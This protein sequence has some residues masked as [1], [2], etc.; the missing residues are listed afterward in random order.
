MIKNILIIIFGLALLLISNYLGHIYPPFSISW[1]PILL[2]LFTILILFITNF[3]LAI[4]FGLITGMIIANDILIKFF[5]GGTHDWEG[6]GWITGFLF[7]GLIISSIL[8]IVYGF[9]KEKNRKKEYFLY[10]FGSSILLFAY[11]SYFE[12][13]GMVWVDYPSENINVSK[14]KGLFISEVSLSDSIVP[15][16]KDTFLIKQGWVEQQTKSNHKGILIRTEKTDK[17]YCTLILD[18]NFKHLN[19]DR[20]I[21]YKLDNSKSLGYQ[22]INKRITLTLDNKENKY[23]LGFYRKDWNKI[24]DIE[25]KNGLY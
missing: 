12:S 22:Y 10:L 8:A 18:G 4:K 2:G 3:R 19:Y 20:I 11:L 23:I 16:D 6:V 17:L 25:I 13:L 14:K 21:Y 7:L 9:L 1:T 15:Y 24:K 5:A